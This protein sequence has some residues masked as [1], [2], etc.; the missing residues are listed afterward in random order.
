[1]NQE[2]LKAQRFYWEEDFRSYLTGR[3]ALRILL[4]KYLSKSIADIRFNE[5][6]KKPTI[7][8]NSALKY[9]LSY[10]GKYILISIGLCETGIDVECINPDL[11]FKDILL[12][13][14]S[15]DEID[16]IDKDQN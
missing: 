9:N 12:S 1:N 7:F 6:A 4:S 3:I 8:S 5:E 13:C 11:D 15:K 16:C 10:A 14:Y 2:F